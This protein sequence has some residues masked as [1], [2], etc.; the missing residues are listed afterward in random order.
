VCQATGAS[1][2]IDAPGEAE[3]IVERLE[4][5]DPAYILMTHDHIDHVGALLELK[6]RLGVPVA[7][8][9]SDARGLPVPVDLPLSDGDEVVFG[10]VTLKVLHTPGHTPGSLC[11]LTDRYLLSGDTIFPGGP[12]RTSSPRDLEQVMESLTE[13]IFVLPDDTRIHPGH[14]EST[15]LKKEKDEFAAF[16]SRPHGSGLCGEILWLTS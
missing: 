3:R 5:T 13:K 9:P 1:V 8:H 2:L 11:F 15:V 6:D 10:K 14:G 12:G 7:A 4:G 16:S